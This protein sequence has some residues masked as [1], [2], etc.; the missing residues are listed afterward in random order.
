MI[1][2]QHLSKSYGDVNAVID[3]SFQLPS[4]SVV[5]LLGP[6]GAGK[7]T[8]M[9]MLTTYLSPTSGTALVAGYDVCSQAEKVREVIGYLPESPPLYPELSVKDFLSYV[10]R[11]KG[12]PSAGV[13]R[14]V[15]HVCERC[16]LSQVKQ[17]L[18]GQLSKGFRQRVGIAHALV[19]N[20][21]VIILDEPT[22]GL[23]PSQI[24]EIRKLIA[25]LKDE[26]TVILSTHILAEVS[27][28]C[29]H[30]VILAEGRVVVC[31]LLEELT[32]EMSLE[33]QFMKAIGSDL[34][35]GKGGEAV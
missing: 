4:G 19:H 32:L 22:S 10:A 5:G 12:L 24:L 23:D 1:E 33:E 14:A 26:H 17:R 27:A 18:C 9:R 29:S 16:G 3:V 15:E 30:V 2:A 34:S 28:A 7:T 20:P 8:T 35:L 21:K 11:L 6:N 31:G 25:S 13:S